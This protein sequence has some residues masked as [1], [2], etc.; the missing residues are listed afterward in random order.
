MQQSIV[1]MDTINKKLNKSWITEN[2]NKNS[3]RDD[4]EGIP[5]HLWDMSGILIFSQR[6][7]PVHILILFLLFHKFYYCGFCSWNEFVFINTEW[8][9]CM[10]LD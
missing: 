1:S 3:D 8:K 4:W 2:Y 7:K 10:I 5:I 6:I 9:A